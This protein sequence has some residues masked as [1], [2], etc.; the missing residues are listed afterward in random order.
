MGKKTTKKK[1]KT[2]IP[3]E[4]F[5]RLKDI[6]GQALFRDVRSTF[7]ERPTTFRV[8]TIKASREDIRKSLELQGFKLLQVS[9]CKDAFILRNKSKRELSKTEEYLDGKIYMQSLAS[10]VPPLVLSPEPGETVLDLTAAPGSKTSQMAA[11]MEKSGELLANDKNKIRFFKLQSNM[12]S[13]GVIDEEKEAWKFTL[14]MEDGVK[15]C[16]EYDEPYFDRILLDAV[17]SSEA[18]FVEGEPKTFAFWRPQKIKE[19]AYIQQK[20]LLG[21]WRLLKPGGVLV[22][23]TCTWAPEENESRISKLL[24]IFP[25]A[26]VEKIDLPGLK[27]L[28]PVMEWRGRVFD[29]RVMDTMRIKPDQNIEGFFVARV[30]KK[31]LGR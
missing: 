20:L 8:N 26:M 31:E 16:G 28:P 12:E 2:E 19:V 24:E 7:V 21:A 15:L 22:Y 18:R 23:S 29:E 25:D 1:S 14:R 5:S 17:C 27:R 4:F 13:L 30:R 3:E 6:T 11:M 9:W 10:M